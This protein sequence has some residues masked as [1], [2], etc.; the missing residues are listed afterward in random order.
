[1]RAMQML[2]D[3]DMLKKSLLNFFWL[4]FDQFVKLVGVFVISIFLARILGPS[5]YGYYTYL[6]AFV[7]IFVPFASAGLPTLGIKEFSQNLENR[8]Q[9][10][11]S[12][13]FLQSVTSLL[14][15]FAATLT[16]MVIRPQDI[17][18]QLLVAV[19]M[20]AYSLQSGEL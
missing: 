3:R 16:M 18:S 8:G 15:L 19:L 11:G 7:S 1:M 4:S 14:T 6:F 20:F 9:I 17:V 12:M 5:E 10:F 2:A 13:L